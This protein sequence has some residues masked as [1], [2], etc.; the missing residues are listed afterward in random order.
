MSRRRRAIVWVA[1][2]LAVI[3]VGALVVVGVRHLVERDWTRSG[4]SVR[5]YVA[6]HEATLTRRANALLA[7]PPAKTYG[8]RV[9]DEWV[10]EGDD[11]S[12]YVRMDADA[13]PFKGFGLVYDPHLQLEQRKDGSFASSEIRGCWHVRDRWFWCQVY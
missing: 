1:G 9:G 10:Y 4:G 12:M 13:V 5:T 8:T 3:A 7:N 2:V 11:A 6:E